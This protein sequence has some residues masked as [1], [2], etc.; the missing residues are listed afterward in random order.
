MGLV[1]ATEGKL[2][3]T[4]THTASRQCVEDN[5]VRVGASNDGKQTNNGGNLIGVQYPIQPTSHLGP[6]IRRNCYKSLCRT[7]EAD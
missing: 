1:L 7:Q 3:Q 5:G 4:A 6:E 2:R